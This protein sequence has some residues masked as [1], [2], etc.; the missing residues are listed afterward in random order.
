ME[1]E[2]GDDEEQGK[3]VGIFG[4]EVVSGT[5]RERRA[6]WR[7]GEKHVPSFPNLS[8]TCGIAV[9]RAVFMLKDYGGRGLCRDWRHGIHT[10]SHA[11]ILSVVRGSERC[12]HLSA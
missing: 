1:V 9:Q 3:S 12:L 8:F 10:V 6:T 11:T 5:R 7:M 2:S 4:V